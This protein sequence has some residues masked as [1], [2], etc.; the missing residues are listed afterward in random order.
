MA[1][2]SRPAGG[3][4]RGCGRKGQAFHSA[5]SIFSSST[6]LVLDSSSTSLFFDASLD[7]SSEVDPAELQGQLE[8]PGHPE[9]EPQG[10]ENRY[11]GL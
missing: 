7:L 2:V 6:P 8:P 1:H 3:L 11:M 4:G 10:K 9:V 5:A